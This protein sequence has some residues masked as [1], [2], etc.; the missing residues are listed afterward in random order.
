MGCALVIGVVGGDG[1]G[2]V[3]VC[4]H[5]STGLSNESAFHPSTIA[6]KSLNLNGQ[7]REYRGSCIYFE[8]DA[9]GGVFT[10]VLF[11]DDQSDPEVRA[12]LSRR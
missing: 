5:T 7:V 9:T 10:G 8:P 1:A 4:S 2:H 11:D 6:L 3:C 12:R